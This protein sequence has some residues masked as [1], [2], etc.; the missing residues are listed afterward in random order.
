[1]RCGF[2]SQRQVQINR[3]IQND[4]NEGTGGHQLGCFSS[5][6]TQK[7]P[8]LE[9]NPQQ[10]PQFSNPDHNPLSGETGPVAIDNGLQ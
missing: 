1:M 8:P 3:V 2:K 4:F 7:P 6:V 10:P 5:D 9:E